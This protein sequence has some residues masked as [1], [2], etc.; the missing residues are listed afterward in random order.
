LSKTAVYNIFNLG[1]RLKKKECGEFRKEKITQ[2][3][4]ELAAFIYTHLGK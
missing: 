2:K 4:E 1:I 3:G